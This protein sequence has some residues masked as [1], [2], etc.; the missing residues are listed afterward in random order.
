M[1]IQLNDS[2]TIYIQYLRMYSG[3]SGNEWNTKCTKLSLRKMFQKYI[4]VTR[5][6]FNCLLNKYS[7]I[8]KGALYSKGWMFCCTFISV[9]LTMIQ[10]LWW[11]MSHKRKLFNCWPINYFLISMDIHW[12]CSWLISLSFMIIYTDYILLSLYF[13]MK[14]TIKNKDLLPYTEKR[15]E[16]ALLDLMLIITHNKLGTDLLLTSSYN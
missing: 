10:W 8:N 12:Y 3:V 13:G 16:E 1:S 15:Y 14:I 2:Y 11:Y 9:W 7:V 6:L 4:L 5:W